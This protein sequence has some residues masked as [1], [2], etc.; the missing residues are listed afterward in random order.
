VVVTNLA[1]GI[2]VVTYRLAD[3]LLRGTGVATIPS[4]RALDNFIATLLRPT[5]VEVHGHR[6]YLRRN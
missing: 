1:R 5:V 6:M 4:V 3:R 2:V